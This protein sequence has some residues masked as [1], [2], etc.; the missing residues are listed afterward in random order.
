M[1]NVK[2]D[3]HLHLMNT[4][5]SELCKFAKNESDKRHYSNGVPLST[6]V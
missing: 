1:Y 6:L 5:G 4:N 2:F 3:S